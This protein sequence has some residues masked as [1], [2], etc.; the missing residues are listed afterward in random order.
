ME[1]RPGRDGS[2]IALGQSADGRYVR[3]VYVPDDDGAGAFIVTA[4][5]LA[6]KPLK[7]FRRRQRR[8]GT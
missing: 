3:I 6:G 4:Y 7:A 1:D 5:Q 8:R 2:R